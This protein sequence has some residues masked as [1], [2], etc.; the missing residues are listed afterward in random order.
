M[1]AVAGRTT[2][3]R[4]RVLASEWE[5]ERGAYRPLPL[6]DA[7]ARGGPFAPGLCLEI[8]CGTGLLTPL[9]QRVWPAVL[10][11]DLSAAMLARPAGACGPS[12]A[13]DI[14][15]PPTRCISAGTA[16]LTT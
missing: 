4:Y 14:C 13:A 8:G 9:L 3:E 1:V 6:T 2:I 7:L 12:C 11:L 16:G 10:G 5:G 15:R